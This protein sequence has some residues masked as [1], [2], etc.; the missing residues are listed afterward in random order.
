MYE[1]EFAEAE[2]CRENDEEKDGIARRS[3]P[4]IAVP[5]RPVVARTA[6]RPLHNGESSP[7]NVCLR[8]EGD[9]GYEAEP[10]VYIGWPS[11]LVLILCLDRDGHENPD[12]DENKR[13]DLEGPVP[14]PKRWS[15]DTAS[16][17]TKTKLDDS[18]WD[19]S[20]DSREHEERVKHEGA[21]CVRLVGENENP[22]DNNKND[23]CGAD[24]SAVL[25]LSL[26]C[27]LCVSRTVV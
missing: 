26:E 22:E 16:A 13:G 23:N 20:R 9:Q 27:I 19:E 3:V 25:K 8:H 17:A 15:R 1:H 24:L 10:L 2:N 14:T 6:G 7:A 12:A 4:G 18:V 5:P 11:R 21:P